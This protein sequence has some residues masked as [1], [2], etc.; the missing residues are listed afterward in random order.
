M[1]EKLFAKRY[2][3]NLE[4]G[5]V[6]A[7]LVEKLGW[8]EDQATRVEGDY[9]RFLYS[10]AH[11]GEGE[12]LSPPSQEV[13]EF[14]HQHILDT[15]RYREDCYTAFGPNLDQT[16]GLVPEKHGEAEARG[17]QYYSHET[18]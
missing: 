6:C 14:W 5:S 2:I 17:V 13:D 18:M 1:L 15:R 9:K 4:L 11:R 7:K 3:Q 16:R 10:L 8:S 12:V